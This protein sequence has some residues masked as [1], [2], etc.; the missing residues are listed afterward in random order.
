M[1][2][3]ALSNSVIM[4]LASLGCRQAPAEFETFVGICLVVDV[5]G[6]GQVGAPSSQLTCCGFD[7]PDS[8]GASSLFVVANHP[9]VGS[10]QKRSACA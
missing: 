5:S 3:F 4:S 7:A 2:S 1:L 10:P 9:F 8:V 6:A